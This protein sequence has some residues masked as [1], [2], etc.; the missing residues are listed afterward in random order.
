M[1]RPC[2]RSSRT[3]RTE[4]RLHGKDD[5]LDAARTPRAALASDRLR[6]RSPERLRQELRV[7]PIGKLL[8]RYSRLRR[9]AVAAD[10]LATRLVLRSLA[11]QIQA[12]TT[13]ADELEPAPRLRSRLDLLRELRSLEVAAERRMGD[14]VVGGELPQGLAGRPASDELLVGYEPAQSTPV[15]HGGSL[16]A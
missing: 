14:V 16:D 9:T 11:R 5:T 13:E 1:A 3:P 8:A 2:S 4:R 10:E 7:L 12:A 6:A 15:L